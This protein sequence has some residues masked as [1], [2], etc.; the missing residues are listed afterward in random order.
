[1]PRSRPTTPRARARERTMARIVELGNAQLLEH[2]ASELSLRQVARDL[3]KV[4]SAI[5]R[6]VASRDE[7]LTLL[8]V[9]AYVDLAE[10]VDRALEQ[11]GPAPRERFLVL[12]AAMRRWALAHPER[13]TLL[14]GTPVRGYEA[15]AE[16][17][18]R[19]GIRVAVRV[20]EIAVDA[21]APREGVAP[22]PPATALP[23][24]VSALVEELLDEL[25]L[26][27]DPAVAVRAVTAW[28]ALIGVISAHVFGQLG[29]DAVALGDHLLAVQCRHLADLIVPA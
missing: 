15:P 5:Y 25:D 9:D 28:S 11:A 18:T 23:E 17:T 8:I 3:G 21:D 6:Y 24:G 10:S 29:D 26:A 14:Y 13:W 4:S 16:S 22:A 19:D 12:A 27:L 7:L 1:M 2:G 20:L